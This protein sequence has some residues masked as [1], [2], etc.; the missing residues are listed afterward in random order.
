MCSTAARITWSA[1]VGQSMIDGQTSGTMLE[2]LPQTTSECM[3]RT[4]VKSSGGGKVR[5]IM[6][7]LGSSNQPILIATFLEGTQ[8]E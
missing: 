2:T 8:I 6:H 4:A 7:E 5:C 3:M 1:A